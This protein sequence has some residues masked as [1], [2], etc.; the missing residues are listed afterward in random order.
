M[1][2]NFRRLAS[3]SNVKLTEII[4]NEELIAKLFPPVVNSQDMN[5]LLDDVLD[6]AKYKLSRR[7]ETAGRLNVDSKAVG[8]NHVRWVSRLDEVDS[9]SKHWDNVEVGG[10][11][12]YNKSVFKDGVKTLPP[13][14][15]SS[16]EDTVTR[17]Y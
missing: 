10:R 17:R 11:N 5:S 12:Y 4:I 6:A 16:L 8:A 3:E 7:N 1:L 15:N 14:E 13:R 9:K 2:Y